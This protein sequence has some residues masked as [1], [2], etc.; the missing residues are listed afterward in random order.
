[1]DLNK[2]EGFMNKKIKN[3]IF[4]ASL[5]YGLFLIKKIAF[6]IYHKKVVILP[7]AVIF[8]IITAIV[9]LYIYLYKKELI[10]M[11]VG[12]VIA[13]IGFII[14]CMLGFLMFSDLSVEPIRRFFALIFALMFGLGS[15]VLLFENKIKD[16][17]E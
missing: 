5:L 6:L 8:S 16:K 11:F 4:L 17:R 3:I 10:K 9:I 2:S 14:F 15:I 1:M 12:R 7:I 13:I